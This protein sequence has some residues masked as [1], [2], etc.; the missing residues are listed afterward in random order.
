MDLLL[1]LISSMSSEKAVEI[2][3]KPAEKEVTTK[4]DRKVQELVWLVETERKLRASYI[5]E[6][7]KGNTKI[8]YH[9][10]FMDIFKNI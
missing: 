1:S 10:G 9:C 5:L 8:D 4:N 6:N 2:F 3:G 7:E